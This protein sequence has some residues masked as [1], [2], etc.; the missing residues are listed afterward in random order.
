MRW[1]EKSQYS[2]PYC[3]VEYSIGCNQITSEL[4]KRGLRLDLWAF[5]F[6]TIIFTTMYNAMRLKPAP[7]VL[8]RT[9]HVD[10]VRNPFRQT[11]EYGCGRYDLQVQVV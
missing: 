10:R 7:H 4:A 5:S 11:N 1:A 3:R 8:T 9:L 6:Y 2:V